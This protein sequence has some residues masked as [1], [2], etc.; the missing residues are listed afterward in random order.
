MVALPRL[1]VVAGILLD[2]AGSV[3]L[4]ERLGDPAF[5]G[6]WE[7]PGGKRRYLGSRRVTH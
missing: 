2:G 3:L 7:F 5:A 4:A 6:L 1:K